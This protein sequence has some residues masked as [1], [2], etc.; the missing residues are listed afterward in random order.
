MKW[1]CQANVPY[2]TL[3]TLVLFAQGDI[4]E[5]IVLIENLE[6]TKRTATDIAEKVQMAQATSAK[7]G[8][9]R[10]IYR[11]VAARGALVYFL[12]DALAALDRVYHY[13]MATFVSILSKGDVVFIY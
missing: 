7:I 3:V 6:G 12:V 4:L 9:A 5:D 11:S 2:L 1:Y 13:T 10:E 8:K